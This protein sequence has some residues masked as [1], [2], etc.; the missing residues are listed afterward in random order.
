[1]ALPL[2]NACS[3]WMTTD[4]TIFRRNHTSVALLAKRS[5]GAL[6]SGNTRT[7]MISLLHPTLTPL[8]SDSVTVLVGGCGCMGG[9]HAT[10]HHANEI[11]GPSRTNVSHSVLWQLHVLH[12]AVV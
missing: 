7:P 4:N 12:Q 5:G 3:M 1:M 6:H 11:S 9:H 10:S 8:E 2:L